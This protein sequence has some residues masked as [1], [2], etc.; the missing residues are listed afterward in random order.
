M[1]IYTIQISNWRAA[2]DRGIWI[3]D[4]TRRGKHPLFAPDWEMVMGHKNGTVSDEQYR[5]EYYALLNNRLHYDPVPWQEFYMFNQD[6]PIALG[7]YCTPGDFC[8]RH[9]LVPMLGKL[10][11]HWGFPYTYYGEL[12]P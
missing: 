2:R 5:R 10:A 12:L 8:H 6:R 1:D 3:E 9:L 4:T 7:C 11:V